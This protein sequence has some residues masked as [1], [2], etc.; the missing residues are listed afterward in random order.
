MEKT[1]K[2]ILMT[3]VGLVILVSL[4]WLIGYLSGIK[5]G[6]EIAGKKEINLNQNQADTAA[7]N[8]LPQ[9]PAVPDN[10]QATANN[11]LPQAPSLVK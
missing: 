3:V 11:L 10:Y 5:I 9:I 2:K 8:N 7:N 1:K 4:G 6:L